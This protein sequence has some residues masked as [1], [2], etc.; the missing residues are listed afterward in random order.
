MNTWFTSREADWS[1]K[2]RGSAAS[3]SGRLT[4]S[5]CRSRVRMCRCF[6][7][8]ASLAPSFESG[9]EAGYR[10]LRADHA[11]AG[12]L[13]SVRHLRIA[14]IRARD[15]GKLVS[16]RSRRLLLNALL[17]CATRGVSSV[18]RRYVRL[19]PERLWYGCRQQMDTLGDLGASFHQRF[20]DLRTTVLREPCNRPRSVQ[21]R[22]WPA[23]VK[24]GT[25]IRQPPSIVSWSSSA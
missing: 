8:D 24:M 3:I 11:S 9:S 12:A 15:A 21:P 25:P 13:S 16:S 22:H 23:L 19:Q 17:I 14:T 6:Y 4:S 1:R 10:R 18:A 5:R 20:G 7:I 2:A